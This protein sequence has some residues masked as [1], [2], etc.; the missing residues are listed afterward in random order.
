MLF[1]HLT[2]E[3][4]IG[5]GLRQWKVERERIHTAVEETADLLDIHHLLSRFPGTLSG[6]EQQRV[7]L[8]RALILKPR[9][10]LL[11]EPM[12]ALDTAM[13]ERM[14]KELSRIHRLTGHNGDPDH[15]PFRG[16]VYAC[17]QGRDHEKRNDRAGGRT[18]R[19]ILAPER[20]LRGRIFGYREP[21]QRDC[22]Q[23]GSLAEI[24]VEGNVTILAASEAE[25]PWSQ[26]CTRRM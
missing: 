4:N 25:G 5:F 22:T 16:C 2:V 17:R 24:A 19:S 20:C 3:D 18:L 23:A 12:N 8:A 11:D 7:A 13:R 21:D 26:P 6:G 15:P 1:P 14:R 10:L 9:V